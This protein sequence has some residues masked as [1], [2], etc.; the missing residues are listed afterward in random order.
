M[1]DFFADTGASVQGKHIVEAPILRH[2]IT[3]NQ[4]PSVD[5]SY[6]TFNNIGRDQNNANVIY[7]DS[8]RNLEII[9]LRIERLTHH[10]AVFLVVGFILLLGTVLV[11]VYMY[12]LSYFRVWNTNPF[13]RCAHH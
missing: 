6:G 9:A 13:G 4:R 8:G 1:L 3:V 2:Q 11:H 5:A 10:V 7:I 12:A